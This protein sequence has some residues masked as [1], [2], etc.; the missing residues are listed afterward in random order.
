MMVCDKTIAMNNEFYGSNNRWIAISLQAKSLLNEN[1]L[2]LNS[3]NSY[4]NPYITLNDH[5]THASS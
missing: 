1:H 5:L 2:I 4:A 3:I